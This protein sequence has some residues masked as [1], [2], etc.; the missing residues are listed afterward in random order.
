[1]PN[2]PFRE[3]QDRAFQYRLKN[4]EATQRQALL[5]GF[6]IAQDARALEELLSE[7]PQR[8]QPNA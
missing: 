4:P 5:R 2:I 6:S 1:M 3:I 8:N 7:D